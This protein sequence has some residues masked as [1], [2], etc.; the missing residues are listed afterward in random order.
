MTNLVSR[1]ME[2][3]TAKRNRAVVAVLS[4]LCVCLLTYLFTQWQQNG[5][6]LSVWGEADLSDEET[7]GVYYTLYEPPC[8]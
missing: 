5:T 2:Y 7:G 3:D 4:I 6:I 8:I 1:K